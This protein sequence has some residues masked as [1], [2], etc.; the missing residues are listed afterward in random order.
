ML[1]LVP[2]GVCD[3]SWDPRA[4]W[5]GKRAISTDVGH[6]GPPA[7]CP[8]GRGE[9]GA[10]RRVHQLAPASDACR[11]SHTAHSAS[12]GHPVGA[13]EQTRQAQASLPEQKWEVQSGL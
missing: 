7:H 1:L 8:R 5:A 13:R 10:R 2:R 3:L 4:A 12:L 9:W 11:H 6:G